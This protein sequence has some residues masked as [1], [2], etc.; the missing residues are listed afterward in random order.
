MGDKKTKNVVGAMVKKRKTI[1][2]S[3]PKDPRKFVEWRR[4]MKLKI[5]RINK[6]YPVVEVIENS[7]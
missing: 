5:D 3:P 1:P 7:E 2:L 6:S 4:L